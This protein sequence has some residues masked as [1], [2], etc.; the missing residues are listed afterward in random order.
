MNASR[1]ELDGPPRAQGLLRRSWPAFFVLLVTLGLTLLAA[2]LA[3][4]QVE[5]KI[6]SQIEAQSS[7][8]LTRLSTALGQ[9]EDVL[10]SLQGLYAMNIQVVRDVF[11]LFA[12]APAEMHKSV[13]CIAYAPRV[14]AG[15][16]QGYEAY[17]RNQGLSYLQFTVHPTGS[18]AEYYP[19]EYLVPFA[20]N[21][22]DLGFDLRSETR[23]AAALNAVAQTGEITATTL[24]VD[25]RDGE[26]TFQLIA[27][28]Y[29]EFSSLPTQKT[30]A[31]ALSGVCVVELYARRFI[32]EAVARDIDSSM[33]SVSVFDGSA[34]SD[35]SRI[36]SE[37][38]PEA[39][40]RTRTSNLDFAG[41]TWTVE[42]HA[43]KELAS[44]INTS[45]PWYVLITGAVI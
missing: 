16:L 19:L 9:Q 23:R 26:P 13:K 29:E 12:T 5:T 18:R 37:P 17:A 6:E 22:V 21:A 1:A 24:L 28:I 43:G 39:A 14:R 38:L 20:R 27:P 32:I 40:F 36:Y 4:E 25:P 42:I 2:R 34:S 8:I 45:L 10:R 41:H 7:A 31:K 3:Q 15:D 44:T 35:K 11:E 30:S 33:V